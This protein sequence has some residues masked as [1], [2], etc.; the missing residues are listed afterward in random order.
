MAAGMREGWFYQRGRKANSPLSID[1]LIAVLRQ[2][3]NPLNSLVRNTNRQICGLAKNV[4]QVA[5]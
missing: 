1:A 3:P 4:P 5:E 2:R